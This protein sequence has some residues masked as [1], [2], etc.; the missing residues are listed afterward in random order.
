MSRD[1]KYFIF[2]SI[3]A[4]LIGFL[5]VMQRNVTMFLVSGLMISAFICAYII[6]R[7]S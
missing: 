6:L 7:I 3:F 2:I 4:G 1:M 5:A